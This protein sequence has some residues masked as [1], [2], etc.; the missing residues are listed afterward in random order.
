MSTSQKPLDSNQSETLAEQQQRCLLVVGFLQQLALPSMFNRELTEQDYELWQKLLCSYPQKAIE[1][2]FENWG[3][4]G[5]QFPKPANILELIGAWSISNKDEFRPCVNCDSGWV[6]VFDGR[7]A[8][9]HSVDPKIGAVVR[10]QCLID[11]IAQKK[12]KAA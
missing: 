12:A 4:N 3:R 1:Y 8:K 5:K 7:K 11:W 2:A 9:G 10:C 6:R